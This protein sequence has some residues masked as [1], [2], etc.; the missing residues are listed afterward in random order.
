MVPTP[1]AM[2]ALT[3]P[4]VEL[5]RCEADWAAAHPWLVVGRTLSRAPALCRYR[6]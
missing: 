6:T 1:A 3:L 4:E 2:G 5:R